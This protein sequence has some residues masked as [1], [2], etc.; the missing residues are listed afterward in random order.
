MW[1]K[2]IYRIYL[3]SQKAFAREAIQKTKWCCGEKE[4]SLPG[5]DLA[6][7]RQEEKE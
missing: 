3:I 5:W 2:Y 6:R 7:G 4:S 1:V